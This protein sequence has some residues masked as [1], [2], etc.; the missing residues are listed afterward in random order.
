MKKTETVAPKKRQKLST[1]IVIGVV[2]L[3]TVIALVMGGTS[4]YLTYKSATDTMDGTIP[5]A[6]EMASKLLSNDLRRYRQLTYQLSDTS[7]FFV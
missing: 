5:G 7:F 6:A 4:A 1:T 3:V 2:V